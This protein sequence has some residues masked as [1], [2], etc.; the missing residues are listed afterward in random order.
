MPLYE[1]YCEH[2]DGIFEALKHSEVNWITFTSCSTVE[3]FLAMIGGEEIDLS[4]VRLAAIGPV[5][6]AAIQAAG[7]TPNVVA[8]PHTAE[9]LVEAMAGKAKHRR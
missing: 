6:A 2:C 1:Y 9:A 4:P 5:T 8:S 3:N 7:L